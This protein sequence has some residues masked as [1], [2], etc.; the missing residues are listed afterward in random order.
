VISAKERKTTLGPSQRHNP[1]NGELETWDIFENRWVSQE[2]WD[3]VNR[4]VTRRLT[5][6]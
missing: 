6:L 4:R 2:Y 3:Y 5:W 1:D